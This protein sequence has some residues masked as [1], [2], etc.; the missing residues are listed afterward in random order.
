MF[1]YL[2]AIAFFLFPLMMFS[3]SAQASPMNFEK[4]GGAVCSLAATIGEVEYNIIPEVRQSGGE[5][6][7]SYFL[8][9]RKGSQGANLPYLKNSFVK[10][11]EKS[12]L[13][14]QGEQITIRSI[15]FEM[16]SLD[17]QMFKEIERTGSFLVGLSYVS[18]RPL[19]SVE[20]ANNSTIYAMPGEK[21][22]L[23]RNSLWKFDQ[24]VAAFI[25]PSSEAPEAHWTGNPYQSALTK[26]ISEK[27]TTDMFGNRLSFEI[28]L[29]ETGKVSRCVM[30]NQAY[31]LAGG[32]E[33][34]CQTLDREFEF[35]PQFGRLGEPL[36][37][38]Y[39]LS[40]NFVDALDR[41]TAIIR[42]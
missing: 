16:Y 24:C 22:S 36:E 9:L 12:Q 7:V 25:P 30:T 21:F 35:Q 8:A 10:S 4:I 13:I 20:N 17:L 42:Y 39:Q 18:S 19:T 5:R 23:T 37:G 6:N 3:S 32:S 14:R 11:G 41:V 1:N 29:D 2:K 31:A 34:A 28:F 15:S 38:P 27:G 26:L 40:V 33:E